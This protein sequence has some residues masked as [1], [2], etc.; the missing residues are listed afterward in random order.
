MRR[1]QYGYGSGDVSYGIGIGIG[2]AAMRRPGH[3]LAGNE[4]LCAG[5]TCSRFRG[6]CRRPNL[7]PRICPGSPTPEP[8]P[9]RRPDGEPVGSR[10]RP[11]QSRLS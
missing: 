6:L 2:L 1:V 3:R 11:V 10:L 4:F 7:L 8:P 9:Q 5:V